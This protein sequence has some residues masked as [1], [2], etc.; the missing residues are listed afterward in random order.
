MRKILLIDDDPF[1]REGLQALLEVK[2]FDVKVA[3]NGKEAEQLIEEE[4][5]DLVITDIIMPDKDGIEVIIHLRKNYKH[6]KIIA[7]SGGGRINAKDHLEIAGQLGVDDTLTKPFSHEELINTIN[8]L[9][10]SKN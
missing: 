5:P 1:V 3:A 4:V 9:T 8:K 10:A 2:G 7:I 6:I